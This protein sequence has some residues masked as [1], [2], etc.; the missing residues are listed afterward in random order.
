MFY[1]IS[2]SKVLSPSQEIKVK[3]MEIDPEKRRISLSYKAVLGNPWDKLVKESPVGSV[4]NAKVKNI[5]DYGAFIDLGGIDGLVHVTDI[6]WTKIGNPS[7]IL[8]LN[9][10]G[11]V[12]NWMWFLRRDDVYLRNEWANYTNW[13]FQ[14]MFPNNIFTINSVAKY[15]LFVTSKEEVESF[16]TGFNKNQKVIPIQVIESRNYLYPDGHRITPQMRWFKGSCD[17]GLK[18][19]IPA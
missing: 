18:H 6:S 14:D 9:S 12:S 10:L 15:D 19:D 8:E 13:E 16:D 1:L 7:E 17:R 2:P 11:L 3:I 4:V 5:T